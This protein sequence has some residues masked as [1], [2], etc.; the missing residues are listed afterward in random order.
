MDASGS[1]GWHGGATFCTTDQHNINL[2]G[3]IAARIKNFSGVDRLDVGFHRDLYS[4][5][6][7][8]ITARLI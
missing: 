4:D 2:Y 1:T 7:A 6:V 5:C 8:A 3:G